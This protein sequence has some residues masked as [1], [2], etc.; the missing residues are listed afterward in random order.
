[1]TATLTRSARPRSATG[2]PDL[3]HLRPAPRREPGFDDEFDGL[4]LVGPLD[5]QLPFAGRRRNRVRPAPSLP[6]TLP[7]PVAWGHRL[8]I[9]IIET[10]SGHRPL[11]QLAAMLSPSVAAGLGADF[12]RTDRNL[13]RH[14]THAARVRHI[15]ASH[16]VEGVA[17]LTA[18]VQTGRRVRA[19]AL[20]LEEHHGRWR[21]TRLQ[22]G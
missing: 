15:Y 11:Q 4:H 16:P 7:D 5:R 1:M 21:C 8:L 19:I 20:R 6:R 3:R 13:H 10:A 18:T 2:A 17:E 12:E 14:W 22:L 9:G